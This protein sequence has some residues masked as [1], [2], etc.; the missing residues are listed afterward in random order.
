MYHCLYALVL[1]VQAVLELRISLI[2]NCTKLVKEKLYIHATFQ[3][4]LHAVITTM[5]NIAYGKKIERT[6]RNSTYIPELDVL[7]HKKLITRYVLTLNVK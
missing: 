4:S 5:D 7:L 2:K 6:T 3:K 1:P